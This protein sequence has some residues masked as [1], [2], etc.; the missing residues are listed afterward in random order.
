VAGRSL[1]NA[2]AMKKSSSGSSN[3]SFNMNVSFSNTGPKTIEVEP[4]NNAQNASWY[5]PD[6]LSDFRKEEK[7]SITT[8]SV[9]KDFV[10]SLL[11]V[12]NEH[13]NMGIQD[14]KGLRQLSRASSRESMKKALQRA[15]EIVDEPIATDAPRPRRKFPKGSSPLVIQQKSSSTTTKNTTASILGGRG[16]THTDEQ[17][18]LPG[19]VNAGRS[20]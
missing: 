1:N 6:E 16:H 18:F 4:D 11:Q 14:P 2:A 17:L 10:R 9:R 20:S 5:S 12:Q 15:Q 13:K 3:K 19:E 7:S 8:N